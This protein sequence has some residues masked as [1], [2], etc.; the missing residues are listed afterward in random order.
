MV[1]LGQQAERVSLR[2]KTVRLFSS[3]N[4]I[5]AKTQEASFYDVYESGKA[6]KRKS[7]T[8]HTMCGVTTNR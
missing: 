5:K 2:Y 3:V 4:I 7:V 1:S 8:T 6:F